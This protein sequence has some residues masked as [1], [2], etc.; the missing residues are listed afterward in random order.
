MPRKTQRYTEKQQQVGAIFQMLF[1]RS[2]TVLLKP[3]SMS[4]SAILASR[5]TFGQMSMPSLLT[6]QWVNKDLV[7]RKAVL[8]KNVLILKPLLPLKWHLRTCLKHEHAPFEQLTQEMSSTA[9]T[10]EVMASWHGSETPAQ[11]NCRHTVRLKLC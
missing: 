4:V 11:Q 1:Y 6:A 10:V 9:S 3:T 5:L 2:Y 8:P 7:L